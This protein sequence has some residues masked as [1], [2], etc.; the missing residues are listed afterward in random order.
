LINIIQTQFA[1]IVDS[2]GMERHS[3]L[4]PEN[5]AEYA[6]SGCSSDSVDVFACHSGQC[7]G[8]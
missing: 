8:H 2:L 1:T 4:P 3:G 6:N 5:V 7:H